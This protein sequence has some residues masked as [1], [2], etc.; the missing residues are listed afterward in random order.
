MKKYLLGTMALSA[1]VVGCSQEELV[2]QVSEEIKVQEMNTVV[3]HDL[4][5]P[6]AI[7]VGEQ[8]RAANGAWQA[9]DKFGLAWFD[10]AGD[11]TAE[12]KKDAWDATSSSNIYGNHLFS[13]VEGV[14]KTQTNVYQGAHF[15]Y[16]PFEYVSQIGPKTVDLNKK[17]LA[18]SEDDQQTDDQYDRYNNAFHMSTADFIA[19]DDAKGLELRKAFY[20]SPVVNALRIQATPEGKFKD[21]EVLKNL[22][23]TSYSIEVAEEAKVFED[24]FEIV[25]ADI[26]MA[27][28]EKD[29]DGNETDKL[30]EEA[31]KA[32][33][34]EYAIE[35]LEATEKTYKLSRKV[36]ATYTMAEMHEM[37]IYTLPVAGYTS[38]N[39]NVKIIVNIKTKTGLTGYFTIN[40]PDGLADV[41]ANVTAINKLHK[42]MLDGGD[43]TEI[44]RTDAG[45]WTPFNLKVELSEAN[46]TLND[47]VTTFAEWEDAVA[48]YEALG[49]DAELIVDGAINFY[50]TIPTLTNKMITAVTTKNGSINITGAVT[51][52]NNERLNLNNAT[53]KVKK[54]DGILGILTI[55]DGVKLPIASVTNEGIIILGDRSQLGDKDGKGINNKAGRVNVTYGSYAYM[56]E[57]NE[58]IVAYNVENDDTY[59]QLE[60]LISLNNKGGLASVNTFVVGYDGNQRVTLNLNGSK[61]GEDNNDPYNPE[62][63]ALSTMPGLEK[64]TIEMEGGVLTKGNGSERTVKE[65]VVVKGLENEIIGVKVA[66]NLTVNSGTKADMKGGSVSGNITNMGTLDMMDVTFAKDDTDSADD[67]ATIIENHG[68]MTVNAT[69]EQVGDVLKATF[70]ASAD[71]LDNKKNFTVGD[72]IATITIKEIVNADGAKITASNTNQVKFSKMT[73]NGI[74]EKVTQIAQ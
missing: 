36:A 59:T 31:N 9:G 4:V 52:P 12:Q 49:I 22:Q 67:L 73:N 27:V 57:G 50:K 72:G 14:F 18:A 6:I 40:N 39:K 11:I 13:W 47:T 15:V 3:G 16:F 69:K 56:S 5:G 17:P 7:N 2:P 62:D 37:P 28:Y 30:D 42:A 46:F 24:K 54:E 10:I 60:N 32:K 8:T 70:I 74:L 21:A 29:E 25:T 68:E 48:I 71:K 51:L 65:I 19:K 33:L 41:N 55:E 63:G 58:G 53:V 20:L 66:N 1:L 26:P 23:I 61:A 35:K 44:V 38:D 34:D 43:L 45:K 64:I